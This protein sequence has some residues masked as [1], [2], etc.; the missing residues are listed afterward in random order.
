MQDYP[1]RYSGAV[2]VQVCARNAK[3]CP[4]NMVYSPDGHLYN[5]G[6]QQYAHVCIEARYVSWYPHAD[7][8][9]AH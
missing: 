6:Q 5:E 4:F 3:P 9:R 1:T 8:R 2:E 7:E